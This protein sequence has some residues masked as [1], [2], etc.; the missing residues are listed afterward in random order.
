MKLSDLLPTCHPKKNQ[1]AYFTDYGEG[2]DT[3]VEYITGP[4]G[5]QYIVDGNNRYFAALQR[6]DEEISAKEST[7]PD[8]VKEEWSDILLG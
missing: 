6:G 3:P 8:D 1:V 7:L 5:K 4:D 2:F